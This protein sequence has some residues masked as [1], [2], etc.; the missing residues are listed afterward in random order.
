MGYENINPHKKLFLPYRYKAILPFLRYSWPDCEDVPSPRLWLTPIEKVAMTIKKK[1]L[2]PD[3]IRRIH[4]GFSFIPHRFLAHGF[5]AALE[6][7]EISSTVS[8][9]RLR[10]PW[11]LFL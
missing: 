9:A 11:A 3:R 2:N 8:G 7:M 6:Q 4:G 10:P 5:L 1:V